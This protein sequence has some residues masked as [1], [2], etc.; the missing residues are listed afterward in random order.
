MCCGGGASEGA[1][2]AGVRSGELSEVF[3]E[4]NSTP[5]SKVTR[6]NGK[7]FCWQ[8]A[9]RTSYTDTANSLNLE[10]SLSRV[11][12]HAVQILK[13][14]FEPLD[15]TLLGDAEPLA[16]IVVLF[17]GLIVSVGVTDLRL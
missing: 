11:P 1:V 6:Y 8:S 13:G 3:M 7:R 14:H 15:K 5:S 12:I 10:G 2:G 17:V 16:G 4:R 9:S